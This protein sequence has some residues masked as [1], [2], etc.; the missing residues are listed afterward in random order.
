YAEAAPFVRDSFRTYSDK[1]ADYAQSMYDADRID[2]E[3]RGGKRDGAYCMGI[4]PNDSL[5]MMNFK[6]AFGSVSTLAHE[7]GH[8]YHNLCLQGRTVLQRST[9]MTLAETASIF[10]ETVLRQAVLKGDSA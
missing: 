9:P 5:I 10:C 2:A 8:G 6:P 1:M 7:L 3:P 4:P